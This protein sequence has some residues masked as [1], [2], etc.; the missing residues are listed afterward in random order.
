[1]Q[2]IVCNYHTKDRMF[3]GKVSMSQDVKWLKTYMLEWENVGKED[4]MGMTLCAKDGDELPEEQS[5]RDA[6]KA[7]KSR[8]FYLRAKGLRGGASRITKV[9]RQEK[10]KTL[11][12]KVKDLVAE[13]A[14]L[15]RDTSMKEVEAIIGQFMEQCNNAPIDTIK[16]FLNSNDIALLQEMDAE[17]KKSNS[18]K[19]EDKFKSVAHLFFGTKMQCLTDQKIAVEKIISTA[20]AS[21]DFA[22]SKACEQD[23]KFSMS[24]FMS[25]LDKCIIF[26]QGQACGTTPAPV[27]MQT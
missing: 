16:G 22:W 10:S 14:S 27:P 17:I 3:T 5:I 25:M 7:M 1:M 8:T 24:V 11:Q 26:K 15:R 20:K 21:M 9:K 13:V 12:N 4:K 6:M 23:E 19:A 2:V 18:G